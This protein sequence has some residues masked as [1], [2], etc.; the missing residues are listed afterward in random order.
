[1]HISASSAPERYAACIASAL[2]RRLFDLMIGLTDF[3]WFRSI[4]T[5]EIRMPSLN[6]RAGGGS[7]GFT[8]MTVVGL[9]VV[10]RS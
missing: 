8:M 9:G 1:L 3:G 5:S 10:F 4:S 6:T 2:L 7:N